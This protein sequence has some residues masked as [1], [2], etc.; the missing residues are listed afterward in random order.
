MDFP[1][2]TI[3]GLAAA[4]ITGLVLAAFAVTAGAPRNWAVSIPDA[5][6]T[7]GIRLRGVDLFF[8][9]AVGWY[10]EHGFWICVAAV[11]ATLT[12]EGIARVIGRF[13]GP[14]TEAADDDPR[15]LLR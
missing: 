5:T 9:P 15:S 11:A 7:Y 12:A 4:Y 14:S 8:R 6:H 3:P 10:I 2:R 13:G 1:L